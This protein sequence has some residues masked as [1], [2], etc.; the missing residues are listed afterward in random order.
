MDRGSWQATV[1]RVAKSP[2]RLKGLSMHA[3]T[4]VRI[5]PSVLQWMNGQTTEVYPF[6]GIFL[7]NKMDKL[8]THTDSQ[9]YK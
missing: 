5:K 1:H 4:P 7:S 9:C 8:L 3:C 6:N 2:T